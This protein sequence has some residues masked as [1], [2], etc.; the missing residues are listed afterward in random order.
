MTATLKDLRPLAITF[1]ILA[2]VILGAVAYVHAF[3]P[4]AEVNPTSVSTHVTT[5]SG[6]CVTWT[7]WNDHEVNACH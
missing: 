5:D 6:N 1:A 3:G 4:A 7:S 2:A